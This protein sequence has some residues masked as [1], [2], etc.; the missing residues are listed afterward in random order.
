MKL[1]FSY[2]WG[3]FDFP[4][5]LAKTQA[6]WVDNALAGLSWLVLSFVALPLPSHQK[7]YY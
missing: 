6:A 5:E 2:T 4:E 7:V 1:S 3:N